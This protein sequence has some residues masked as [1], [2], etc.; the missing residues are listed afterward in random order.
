M[1]NK[2]V[3]NHSWLSKNVIEAKLSFDTSL[4]ATKKISF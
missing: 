4:E 3:E 1:A 2:R